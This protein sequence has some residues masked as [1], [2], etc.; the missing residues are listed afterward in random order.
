MPPKIVRNQAF[1]ESQNP[2]KDLNEKTGRCVKKCGPR[3]IRDPDTSKCRKPSASARNTTARASPT[4]RNTTAARNKPKNTQAFC[5]SQTPPKDL[6]EKTGRCVKQCGPRQIR[7]PKTSR[8][9]KPSASPRATRAKPPTFAKA[10]T[11]SPQPHSL[12]FDNYQPYQPTDDIKDYQDNFKAT[13]KKL[14]DFLAGIYTENN[15]R[16]PQRYE[17][18]AKTKSP[19]PKTK[20]S[21][22]RLEYKYPSTPKYNKMSPEYSPPPEQPLRLGYKT[23][24]KTKKSPLRLG[25]KSP[26]PPKPV[27]RDSLLKF[28]KT[29]PNKIQQ[30]IN[31][32]KINQRMSDISNENRER[33][34]ARLKSL[35]EK[36]VDQITQEVKDLSAEIKKL[37][38]LMAENVASGVINEKQQDVAEQLDELNNKVESSDSFNTAQSPSASS[39]S[40]F[41]TAQSPSSSSSSSFNTAQSPLSISSI[42]EFS[43]SA[44]DNEN[45]TRKNRLPPP[46]PKK[47][48]KVGRRPKF[49]KKT[50]RKLKK[51]P[52]SKSPES[53]TTRFPSPSIDDLSPSSPPFQGIFTKKSRHPQPY[54]QFAPASKTKKS[55]LL[56]RYSPGFKKQQREEEIER[57][58]AKHG[59]KAKPKHKKTP[60]PKV[61]G[62]T[63]RASP[64]A[65][66]FKQ[67]PEMRG[68]TRR[69]SPDADLFKPSPET[70]REKEMERINNDLYSP[71]FKK[72]KREKEIERIYAKHGVKAKPKHIKK[73][74]SPSHSQSPSPSRWWY[75]MF[76]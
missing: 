74:P 20:K 5:E 16:S 8:C 68:R 61:R 31:Q 1:C 56:L 46:K 76:N 53:L 25:Y 26:S 44:F 66:L 72:H 41:N 38:N 35:E 65:D 7:D 15:D 39:S 62:R 55:P 69:A 63:R 27:N 2:P 19:S 36:G 29:H 18:R 75:D 3:Q 71:G 24:S 43:P 51:G 6:N 28:V 9:R 57:I 49:N 40:S 47:L 45:F 42:D 10:K 60:S 37:D 22:L 59:V 52:S 54:Q 11:P 67:S 50:Q 48:L 21:P 12:S 4:A 64:D 34:N 30:K 13:Q 14:N 58:Y 70:L 32:D 73:T 33:M 17:Q 23:P